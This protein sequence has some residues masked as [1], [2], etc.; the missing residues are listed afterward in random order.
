VSDLDELRDAMRAFTA[1]RN[2]ERF[3]DPKSL[4]LALVGEVGELTELFQWLPAEETV[5]RAA[6]EPLHTRAGEEVA[7]VLLY[8]V[9]LADVLGL[10]L[11]EVADRKLRLNAVKHVVPDLESPPAA[12]IGRARPTG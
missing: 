4:P 10:D 7:D 12:P 3:H 1:E 5:E 2:W 9:Q 8:L 11:R 6:E